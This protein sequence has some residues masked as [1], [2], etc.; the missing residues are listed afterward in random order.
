M[1]RIAIDILGPLPESTRNGNRFIA[2]MWVIISPNGLKHFP[3]P[4]HK[5]ETVARVDGRAILAEIWTSKSDT[6]TLIKEE[7][8]SHTLFKELCSRVLDI[9]KDHVLH[10]GI[11]RVMG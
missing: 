7:T 11:L 5:A 9:E 8:L 6:F 2:I 1:E 10:R 4:N 3:L